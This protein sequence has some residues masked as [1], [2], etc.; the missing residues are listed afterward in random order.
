MVP[1]CLTHFGCLHPTSENLEVSY[2]C[3]IDPYGELIAGSC[4]LTN[5]KVKISDQPFF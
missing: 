3:I 4:W 5:N 1:D 2:L